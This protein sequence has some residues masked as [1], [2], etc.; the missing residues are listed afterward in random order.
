MGPFVSERERWLWMLAG[1]AL[2][3]IYATLGVAGRLAAE[4][5]NRELL[6]GFFFVGF[7]MVLAAIVAFAIRVRLGRAELGVLLGVVAVYLLVFLRAG[8]PAEERTHLIEYTVVAL[9][10]HEALSERRAHGRS[11]LPPGLLA[12]GITSLAGVVDECIQ[13][14]LPSR[15]F[16]WRDVRLEGPR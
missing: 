6:D 5:R 13:A 7:L 10:V 11:G 4:L 14:V 12:L 3:A 2:A 9:L 15:V 8:I 16:D 1:A